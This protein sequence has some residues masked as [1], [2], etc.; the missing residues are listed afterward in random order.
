MGKLA[1]NSNAPDDIVSGDNV[2]GICNDQ[3]VIAETTQLSILDLPSRV[4]LA[5]KV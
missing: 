4:I 3:L 2:D 1:V 5:A